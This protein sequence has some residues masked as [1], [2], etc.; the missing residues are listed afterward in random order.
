MGVNT[1]RKMLI[2]EDSFDGI[3]SGIYDAWCEKNDIGKDNVILSVK[4]NDNLELFM[5][6]VNIEKDMN[7]SL[8]VAESIRRKISLNVFEDVYRTAISAESN[9][10]DILFRYLQLAFKY[11]DKVRQCMAI[12]VVMDVNKIS[13]NVWREYDHYRGFLRFAEISQG[14]LKADIEPKSDLL[15]LLGNHFADRFD[16]EDFIITDIKRKKALIHNKC[17]NYYVMNNIE[18]KEYNNSVMSDSEKKMEDLWRTFFETITI[19][20]RKNKNLQRNNL[21]L[22]FRKYM[23]EFD[24]N[25]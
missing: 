13:R 21:P 9:K 16:S 15:E 3:L 7:K 14:I 6:Y 18:Y 19:E 12:D 25:R 10:A 24:N 11:G 8:K 2:C 4:N 5:E 20:S 1:M 22:H 17:Q 23:T